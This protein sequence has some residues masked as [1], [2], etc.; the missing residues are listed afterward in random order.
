M[1]QELIK[2][3]FEPGMA[4]VGLN[5]PSRRNALGIGMFDALEQA[6]AQIIADESVH[7]VLLHGEGPAFCAG[8]DLGAAVN[9]PALMP[10]F[11]QR[12]NSLNQTLRRMRQIV[13]AAAQGA[14][15]AGGCAILSAC[16]FVLVAADAQLGY[17]VH[18]IGISPAV[19]IPTLQ[20]AIGSGAARSILMSG[21]LIDGA[22]AHRLGLATHLA[23]SGETVLAD[24]LAHCRNLLNKG[25]HALAI[26]KAWLNEL[27]GSLDDSRFDKA[28]E[29]S[30]Q[31]A[32]SEQARSMLA[33]WQRKSSA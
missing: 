20:Q 5:D 6:L 7:V 28:A 16:D 3:K 8:F 10:Q 18:R 14:A 24:A 26:T 17:P 1:S 12:L 15:I 29:A 9:D 23:K 32:T 19:T 30:A 27:D 31:I 25:P 4:M 13:V 11:I 33:R 22:Q 2:L 21:G